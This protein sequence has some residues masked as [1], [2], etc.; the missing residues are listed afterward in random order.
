[1]EKGEVG[2][3]MYFI[4]DGDVEVLSGTGDVIVTM[5][6]GTPFGEMALLNPTPSVRTAHIRAAKDL[7]LAVLSLDDFKFIMQKYPEFAKKVRK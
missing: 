4:I 2:L 1:M 7:A 6:A 5:H 3:E